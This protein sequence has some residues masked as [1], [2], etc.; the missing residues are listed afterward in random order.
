MWTRRELKERARHRVLRNY[1]NCIGVCLVMAVLF[2]RYPINVETLR[3]FHS[4]KDK[5]H[6]ENMEDIQRLVELENAV[7]RGER[8]RMNKVLLTHAGAIVISVFTSAASVVCMAVRMFCNIN[9]ESG[10]FGIVVASIVGGCLFFTFFCVNVMML[11][12][13]RFY[14][15]NHTYKK[16]HLFRMFFLYRYRILKNPICVMALYTI[17]LFL[18]S[19]TIVG[20]LWKSYEYQMVPFLLAENPKI[21]AKMAFSLSKQMMDGQKW[22]SFLLDVSFIGWS[23]LSLCTLGV[24]AVFW[25]ISYRTATRAELY[26][27]L[28][29][30]AL[31]EKMEYYECCNDAYLLG[32]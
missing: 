3:I 12:E 8:S 17:K 28:R 11:G 22:K 13:C 7:E 31:E 32:A 25:G 30:K 20:G 29:G 16:T 9:A 18:W 15:E 4:A 5:M 14:M 23:L 10:N 2:G 27:V 1:W 24:G 19:L 6:I 21:S 26:M